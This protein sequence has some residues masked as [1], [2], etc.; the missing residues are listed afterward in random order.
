M[1]EVNL[2]PGKQ[3]TDKEKMAL[4]D[5]NARL[6]ADAHKMAA[7]HIARDAL[8]GGAQPPVIQTIASS[9]LEKLK[10]LPPKEEGTSSGQ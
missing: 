4:A 3:L 7:D 1:N 6:T 9:V 10:T 5:E 2:T 8:A